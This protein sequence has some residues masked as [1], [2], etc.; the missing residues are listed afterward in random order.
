VSASS[1]PKIVLSANSQ[2]NIVNF[3][4]GLIRA[5][6]EAGFE[7]VVIAPPDESA[8]QRMREL[9]VER[10]GVEVE[11][12]GLNPLADLKLLSAYRR[13]LK[14]MR[15]AAYLGYTIKPNIYGCIAAASAGIP[16]VPN[17][18]GLG[19]AFMRGG[20]LRQ[21]AILLYRFAFRRAPVVFFQNEEDRRLFID[22][23]IVSADRARVV[24]GSGIDLEHFRQ[25]PLPASGPVFLL[26]SRLLRDKGVLEF[27]DA[28]RQVRS[29]LPDARFQLLGPVDDSNRSAVGAAA[30]RSWVEEGIIEY[31]GTTDDVRPYIAEASVIVLPS[32]R[33]G[34]PKS[35]LEGA[36]MGR[37][38]IAADVPGCRDVVEDGLNGYLCPPRDALSLAGAIRK[39]AALPKTERVA[40]GAAGRARIQDRFSETLVIGAYLGALADLGVG[41][42]LV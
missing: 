6:R 19:T 34:L 28:A 5:L 42:Q 4:S 36:A 20:P 18:S 21:L 27:V 11:R 40:M 26:I 15:P 2:W 23:R 41:R 9:G 35:L 17:V 33:E 31:L 37:A 10:I 29:E 16:A 30:V 38:L 24:P 39:M 32:Y 25:V 1:R 8:E 3:R 12:S 22:L 7:P 14:Q 13:L